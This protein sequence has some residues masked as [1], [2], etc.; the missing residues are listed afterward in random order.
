MKNKIFKITELV[1]SFAIS[2]CTLCAYSNT[3][4]VPFQFDDIPCIKGNTTITQ[5]GHISK[6]FNFWPTRFL[7]Y[8][9]FA[10]NYRIHGFSLLG[11]HLINI[12]I[13][14]ACSIL[15][16]KILKKLLKGI[17]NTDN[18]IQFL[19]PVWAGLIFALHP[20]QTQAVTYI[21]QRHTCL[22]TLFILSGLFCFINASEGTRLNIF[23]LS[24]SFVFNIAA[25]FTKEISIVSPILILFYFFW[26]KNAL[27]SKFKTWN[28]VA[29]AGFL[30]MLFISIIFFTHS[31]N[32]AE[33][34]K[35]YS[36]EGN[37]QQVITQKDY[38]LTQG[39]AF[40][41]YFKLLLFPLNQNIDYDIAISKSILNPPETFAGFL[42][43]FAVIISIFILFKKN[44]IISFASAVFV[45]S[46][47]P[48]SS[49]I[50]KPDL[51]V[52]HRLYLP[53]VGYAIFLP[54]F[55]YQKCN[56]EKILATIILLCITIFYGF[57]TYQRN[58]IWNDPVKLWN[59]AVVKS[60][61]KARP[62]LNRGLAFV[63]KGN[64]ER[65]LEDYNTA[66]KINPRYVEAYNNRGILFALMKRYDD[67]LKDFNRA[68]EIKPNYVLSYN[69]RGVL[70]STLGQWKE[71]FGDFDM[72]LKL[73]PSYVDAL[74]NRGIAF[75]IQ[76]NYS[77]AIDDFSKAIQIHPKNGELYNYR[78][79]AYLLSEELDKAKKDT[80]TAQRLNYP[81]DNVLKNLLNE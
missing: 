37:P 59:D 56:K 79:I 72:A 2:A 68:I 34:K 74:K 55:L 5:L 62:Y 44:K 10:F 69:N 38:L 31:I 54:Y 19:I 26:F 41:I 22:A 23:W 14:I 27:E 40:L 46:I 73:N 80:K 51:V 58:S 66:I 42:L 61:Q 28:V 45:I 75:L 20:V 3:F 47:L 71:A 64:I 24:S 8:L 52:E 65:A 11:Y 77:R 48:Q 33:I 53:M 12:T 32:P 15:V 30:C 17:N 6:I 57:L 35:V 50:P 4:S 67:A 70:Y 39:Q 9:S 63:Q 60:P 16:W 21:Y 1:G 13:H 25:M 18:F 29:Y 76:K 81:I 36:L 49:L 43:I 78:A 7:T